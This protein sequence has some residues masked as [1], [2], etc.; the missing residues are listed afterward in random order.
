M[1]EDEKKTYNRERMQAWRSRNASR[2][3]ETNRRNKATQLEV[4]GDKIRAQN[5][6]CAKKYRDANKGKRAALSARRRADERDRTPVWSDTSAIENFYLWAQCAKEVEGLD[7][8][9]DHIIPKH[10]EKVSGFHIPENLQLISA[11]AN[12]R[13]SN[14]FEVK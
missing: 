2:N 14:S 3:A 4:N 5:A 11:E 9:V 7:V 8:H 12:L 13:K 6:I 10:G 1:T